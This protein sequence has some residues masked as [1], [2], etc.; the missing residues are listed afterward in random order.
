[1]FVKPLIFAN[2]AAGVSAWLLMSWW[3][4]SFDA[5]VGISPLTFVSAG[6]VTIVITVVTVILHSVLSTPARSSQPLRTN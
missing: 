4:S 2:L 1:P 6:A 5:H 3:L